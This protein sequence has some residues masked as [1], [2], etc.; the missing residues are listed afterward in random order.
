MGSRARASLV[1]RVRWCNIINK[2]RACDYEPSAPAPSRAAATHS[3]SSH[4]DHENNSRPRTL[5]SCFPHENCPGSCIHVVV[6]A[7][8]VVV[9]GRCLGDGGSRSFTRA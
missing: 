5:E 1:A 8:V 4:N 7:A 2:L 6:S 9:C 3:N